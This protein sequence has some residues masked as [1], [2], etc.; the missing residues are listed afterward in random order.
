MLFAAN[1]RV[2]DD[3]LKLFCNDILRLSL[4]TPPCLLDTLV[5][6]RGRTDSAVLY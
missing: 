3:C 4:G 1:A 2:G 5:V 6:R